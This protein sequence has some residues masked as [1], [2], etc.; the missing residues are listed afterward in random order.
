MTRLTNQAAQRQ[1]VIE[2]ALADIS[3]VVYFLE[4]DE[5]RV[6]Q[7]IRRAGLDELLTPVLNDLGSIRETIEGI[8]KNL[9]QVWVEGQEAR[10]AF[11]VTDST[12]SIAANDY[13]E[14]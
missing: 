1:S 12:M 6:A 10:W 14:L 8:Q 5:L 9:K 11:S 2:N 13:S 4:G 7:A 3:A